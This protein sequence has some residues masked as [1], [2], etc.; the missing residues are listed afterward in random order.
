MQNRKFY[1][2]NPVHQLIKIM[3]LGELDLKRNRSQPEALCAPFPAPNNIKMMPEKPI[4]NINLQSDEKLT[5]FASHFHTRFRGGMG[6]IRSTI[7]TVNSHFIKI[8]YPS[9]TPTHRV[10]PESHFFAHGENITQ[11]FFVTEDTK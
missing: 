6:C 5:F 1:R 10:F 7:G 11:A 2:L 8:L 3:S 9:K 4:H